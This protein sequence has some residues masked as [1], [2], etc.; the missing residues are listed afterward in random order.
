MKF[1]LFFI[2]AVVFAAVSVVP[3]ARAQTAPPQ[4]ESVAS[5]KGAAVVPGWNYFTIGFDGCSAQRILDELQ[6]DAGGDIV[7]NSL[8]VKTDGGWREST[9]VNPDSA[10]VMIKS[11][12]VVAFSSSG[13]FYFDLAATACQTADE[14]RDAQ[15]LGLRAAARGGGAS[16]ESLMDKLARVPRDFWTGLIG[17]FKFGK[18]GGDLEFNKVVTLDR[19]TVADQTNLGPTAVAGSLTVG[20]ITIDDLA[21]SI[22]SLGQSLK[23]Q[24]LALAD[25]EFLGGKIVM[26]KA[27]DLEVKGSVKAGSGV[28][29]IDVPVEQGTGQIV[30]EFPQSKAGPYAVTVTPHWPTSVWISA[31]QSAG[32]LIKFSVPAPAGATL[33]WIVLE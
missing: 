6:A 21:A 28:R 26:T 25:I 7:I 15:I 14:V 31:K 1:R 16:D 10:L 12:D 30:I 11:S 27:G 17:A 22:N 4:P 24:P 2:S 5:A 18:T 23:L 33:D 32:F 9:S 19:L 8:W 13:K 20:L 29:G 3:A